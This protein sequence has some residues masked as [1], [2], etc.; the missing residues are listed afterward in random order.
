[1]V[2]NLKNK[3][4][5][6]KYTFRGYMIFEEITDKSFEGGIKDTIILFYSMLMG[7]SKELSI[8]FDDF[9]DWLDENPDKLS[10]FTEWLQSNIKSRNLRN[11]GEETKED[12]K[13]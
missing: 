5:E 1:M 12:K 11:K 2:I 9:M 7:S 3:L 10:E 13:K 4:I 6:L 8:E